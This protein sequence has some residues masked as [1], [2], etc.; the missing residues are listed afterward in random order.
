MWQGWRWALWWVL[1]GLWALALLT[2]QPVEV[3]KKIVPQEA[4][5]SASKGLHIATYAFLAGTAAWL[6]VW[7]GLRWLPI[8]ILSLHGCGT[9]FFQQWVPARHGC[10][11]D[12]AIDHI[13]IALGFLLTFTR[14]RRPA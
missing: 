14:W 9:E 11:Q 8:A 7:R 4:I 12:V 2:P 3:E 1:V 5:F 13:G 10:L 6:P